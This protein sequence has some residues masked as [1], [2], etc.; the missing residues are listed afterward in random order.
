MSINN[1]YTLKNG[2]SVYIVPS[3][4]TK[5]VTIRAWVF[6]GSACETPANNGVSHFLEHMMFRS[7][8]WLGT[9]NEM[10]LKIEK[11]G[12]DLNAA[13]SFDQVEYW[14]DFHLDFL[15][16]GIRQFCQF[17]HSPLFEQFETER[18]IIAEEILTDYSEAQVLI[19]T[20]TIISKALWGDHSLGLPV[21]GTPSSV[22]NITK[23]ELEDWYKKYY[24]PGNI[25]LGITGDVKKD[26]LL[27][28]IEDEFPQS[29]FSARLGYEQPVTNPQRGQQII[30]VQEKDSQFNLHW[31]FPF[32]GLNPRSRIIW[33]IIG[34]IL[35]DGSTSLLQRYIRE[36]G[37]LAY[38]I[39]AQ[40]SFYEQG[41]TLNIQALVSKA[42][43]SELIKLL[44]DLIRKILEQG[45]SS[46]S[47]AHAKLR[48]KLYLDCVNDTPQ[49]R[50]QEQLSPVL[51]PS[52][53]R[54]SEMLQIID[55]ITEEEIEQNT[56]ILL[57]QNSTCLALVGPL[58]S[59]IKEFI[60]LQLNPWVK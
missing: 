53:L 15:E 59:E 4:H 60:T 41:G 45:F 54:I 33:Q 46:D 30:F 51:H 55:K 43:L 49:G 27:P 36:E 1:V 11:I 20:D 14:L 28:L 18:S 12:G 6:V 39:S 29:E 50:L 34:R 25:I 26:A 57:Q 7:N 58:T 24:Q 42:K 38:D 32:S 48:F 9:G 35:D 21:G 47:I 40:F 13:T 31:S 10:N 23:A 17:L 19:D 3:P 8:R 44:T 2:L 16:Q 37:G 52:L 56:K 22:Q 5:N